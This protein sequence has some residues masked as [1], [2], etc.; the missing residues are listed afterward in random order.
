MTVELDSVEIEDLALLEFGASPKG[1]ERWQMG[2]VPIRRAHPNDD[3]P[4][5]EFHRVKVINRFEISGNF[6]FA[7]LITL[8]FNAVDELFHFR[9]FLHNAIEPIDSGHV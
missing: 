4:V 6:L 3:W 7:C 2:V 9:R 5:F 8:L 1:G